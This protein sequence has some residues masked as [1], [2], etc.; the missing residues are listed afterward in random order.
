[1]P[2]AKA[3]IDR[4]SVSGSRI[5]GGRFSGDA[6]KKSPSTRHIADGRRGMPG[7]YP[8][9]TTPV[10]YS[11]AKRLSSRT[12]YGGPVLSPIQKEPA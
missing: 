12:G 7:Q 3:N 9:F 6:R 1:M 2:Y 4:N 8:A 11:T 5:P 10:V